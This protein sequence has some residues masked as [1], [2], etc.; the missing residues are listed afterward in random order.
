VRTLSSHP[1][2]HVR[3]LFAVAVVALAGCGG[4]GSSLPNPGS[5]QVCDPDAGSISLA[6]P[7]FGF[8]QNGNAIEIVSSSSTDQLH[9]NPSQ[10]DLIIRDN[11]NNEIDTG[12][13]SLVSDT[14]GPH[15]YT[16]D[17]FYAGT[18]LNNASLQFGRTYNV[19][20]NAPNT[21]CTPG[22]VGSFST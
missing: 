9:G 21:N 19:Y 15:P 5:N 4:G 8:S 10:F 2:R 12:V 3:A 7:S 22:F 14:G 17:F 20:L 13:L 18:P 16:N 11:F 6:R 1:S